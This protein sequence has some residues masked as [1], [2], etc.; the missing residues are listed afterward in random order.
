VIRD[1]QLVVEDRADPEPGHGQVMVR[2][3]A[4]GV[5]GADVLQFR[6]GYPA[7]PDAP[8]DVPGLELAGEVIAIG[9][10][11]LRWSEGDRVMALV[12]GGG[13][14]ELAVVNERHLLPVPPGID[15]PEAGGFVEVFATAH[16][17]LF[18]QGGLTTGERLLVQGGAGGVGIAAVQLGVAAG[19]EVVATVRA[20]SLHDAVA[21]FGARVLQPGEEASVAP[22]DVI[23]ELI[24][25]PN[26]AADVAALATEGR[27][28]IIGVSA[29][30]TVELQLLDLMRKRARI[31]GSTLRTRSPEEKARVCRALE[32]HVLP[33]LAS[34]RV[35][36]PV[37]AT[38]PLDEIATAY[39]RFSAG[40]KLGK[41]V[42]TA[43]G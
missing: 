42:V 21:G 37:E 6:G 18:T 16:D 9:P 31:H 14:A 2:V 27:I 43:S 30:A 23:L 26:F 34:H 5:N 1:K 8:A 11:V 38:Y 39:E 25:G 3:H 36:V 35:R 17:A 13:Q 19:A 15:W 32:K 41:I 7:P 20:S 33:L 29:G 4:A 28:L 40:G 10:G 24:G 12:G 22:F